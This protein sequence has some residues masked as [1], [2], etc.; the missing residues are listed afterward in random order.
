MKIGRISL[1]NEIIRLIISH[2]TKR[3]LFNYV[4]KQML[5]NIA[6]NDTHREMKKMNT[7][8]IVEKLFKEVIFEHH[9]KEVIDY[10]TLV[11]F[12]HKYGCVYDS[13]TIKNY[14]EC[15]EDHELITLKKPDVETE[16]KWLIGLPRTN[17][18]WIL[19]RPQATPTQTGVAE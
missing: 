12:F 3:G 19:N 13:R 10:P 14:V 9:D 7:Y 5:I 2:F 18:V 15:A 17:R 8:Q 1:R 11:H 6:P 16:I 4:I